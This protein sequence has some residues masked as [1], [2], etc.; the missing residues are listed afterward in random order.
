MKKRA[1][2]RNRPVAHN[3]PKL[4]SYSFSPRL[5]SS[6]PTNKSRK[7]NQ[8]SKSWRKPNNHSRSKNFPEFMEGIKALV[9]IHFKLEWI[10]DAPVL[11]GVKPPTLILGI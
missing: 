10:F 11:Y 8:F 4:G 3:T 1:W 5:R 9:G 7:W 6:V 2:K